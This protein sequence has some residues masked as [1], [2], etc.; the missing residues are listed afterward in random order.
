MKITAPTSSESPKRELSRPLHSSIKT[1][2]DPQAYIT[3]SRKINTGQETQKAGS[4]AGESQKNKGV[5]HVKHSQ[6]E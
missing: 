2:T 5:F 6:R 3:I 4:K 1:P